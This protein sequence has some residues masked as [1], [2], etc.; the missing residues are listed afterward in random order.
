MLAAVLA[1]VGFGCTVDLIRE[2][3]DVVSLMDEDK[4]QKVRDFAAD[5]VEK[6]KETIPVTVSVDIKHDDNEI[7]DAEV[8]ALPD[9]ATDRKD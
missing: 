8:E 4:N 5:T 1:T 3:G 9:E 6:V 2:D 7:I